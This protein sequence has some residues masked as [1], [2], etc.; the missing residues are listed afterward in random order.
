MKSFKTVF[1]STWVPYFPDNTCGK[2]T[3]ISNQDKIYHP[4][5][6]SLNK[7]LAASILK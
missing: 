7:A 6:D 3:A 2:T 1:P 4:S 5:A